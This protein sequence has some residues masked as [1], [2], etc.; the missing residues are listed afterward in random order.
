MGRGA[1]FDNF[2]KQL[3]DAVSA[4]ANDLIDNWK[5]GFKETYEYE[6]S[7]YYPRQ[8]VNSLTLSVERKGS[9]ETI[10][11]LYQVI[12]IPDLRLQF[13]SAE[14][15]MG[16]DL[17]LNRSE[18]MIISQQNRSGES[19]T[20]TVYTKLWRTGGDSLII[21][22]SRV[23]IPQWKIPDD[24]LMT[25]AGS[26]FINRSFDFEVGDVRDYI[27][28]NL[29][30][31][32]SKEPIKPYQAV[33]SVV[34]LTPVETELGNFNCYKIKTVAPGSYSFTYIT[35]DESQIPILVE[36][37]NPNDNKIIQKVT[38]KDIR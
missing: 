7:T 32:K 21:D 27:S 35:A 28:V 33:D 5:H 37:Y 4:G 3:Q 2:A 6:V 16:S 24:G 36:L 29:F 34:D 25:S 12:D 10:F 11:S 1:D 22:C 26:L 8:T 18:N 23:D 9:V 31:L 13:I 17:Q 19:V 38:L 30:I 14:E 15:Y 20:D